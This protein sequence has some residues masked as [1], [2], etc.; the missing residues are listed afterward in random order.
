MASFYEQ[1]S[2]KATEHMQRDIL[3]FTTQ[4]PKVPDNH[5]INFDIL[6]GWNNLDLEAIQEI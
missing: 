3:L 1:D 2:T 4:F 6:K 5:L